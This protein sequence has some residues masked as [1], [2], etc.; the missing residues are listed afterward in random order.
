MNRARFVAALIAAVGVS[1][2]VTGAGS[3]LW[4]YRHEPVPRGHLAVLPPASS[5][6]SPQSAVGN[7]GPR[8]YVGVVERDTPTP[9]RPRTLFTSVPGRRPN[10]T[11]YYSRWG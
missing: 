7:P 1:I 10:L 6:P 9:Y 5:A 8:P 2:T 4:L 11:A 3:A